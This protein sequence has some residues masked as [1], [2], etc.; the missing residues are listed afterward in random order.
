MA[1][2]MDN[3]I[4]IHKRSFYLYYTLFL[5]LITIQIQKTN[6]EVCSKSSKIST[7]ST[8][9]SCFNEIIKFQGSF[10]AG[11]FTIRNDG[12]LLTE[13]SSGAKR[14]FYGLNPNGRGYFND[15]TNKIIDNIGTQS[16]WKD[17][18][19][20]TTDGRYESKNCLVKLKDDNSVSP[21]E[22][23]L[24]I[25][26][27]HSL[28]ELHDVDNDEFQ[29]WLASKFLDVDKEWR[30]VFSWQFSLMYY[31]D[32][33]TNVYYAAYVQYEGDHDGQAYSVSYSLSK[34]TFNSLTDRNVSYQEF[35][36]NY[37]NRIVSAFIMPVYNRLMV[38]FFKES[39]NAYTLGVH[40][41]D[42]LDKE[43]DYEVNKL[44]GVTLS[45]GNGIF[46][47]AIYLRYQY[48]A[49]MFYCNDG[50][51]SLKFR[52]YYVENTYA[53]KSK[54]AK[55]EFVNWGLNPALTLNEFIC[56][57]KDGERFIFVSTQNALK[58]LIIFFIDTRE[59]YEELSIRIFF[60][61]LEGYCFKMDMD[62]D[63]FNNFLMLSS[64]LSIGSEC[65]DTDPFY[66]ILIFFSYPNGTDFYMN[67]SPYVR[68]SDYY[69]YGYNF[70]NFLISKRTMENNIFKY[71]PIDEVKLIS[72]PEEIIFYSSSSLSTRLTNGERIDKNGIYTKIKP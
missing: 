35:S 27:F 53:T 20:G 16:Y 15:A 45:K 47:K 61:N 66:G 4:Q 41:L 50:G 13:F 24:S 67:L 5:L 55:H 64:T 17:N 8:S 11:Q 34:F 7:S 54:D 2:T 37:D 57:D 59:W 21:K 71:T 68:N 49:A 51:T 62:L 48:F 14:L 46:F 22:Y 31:N 69:Q 40:Y 56:Y 72:I 32:S 65:K 30:Y 33:N 39:K 60:Y 58:K 23:I 3:I 12:V 52:V 28:A 36:D 43:G 9:S 6:S 63:Y 44:E 19:E 26:S 25:S 1:K 18:K 29:I 10:R 42:S 70:I 38:F